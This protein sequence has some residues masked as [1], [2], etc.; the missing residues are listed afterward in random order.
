M[1]DAHDVR[2]QG[3]G[4]IRALLCFGQA[5]RL[6]ELT[7]VIQVGDRVQSH[8]NPAAGDLRNIGTFRT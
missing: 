5:T 6:A 7:N 3:R 1:R 2:E 8:E 4:H